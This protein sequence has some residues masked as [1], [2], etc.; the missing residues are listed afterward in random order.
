[1]DFQVTP[2]AESKAL[3]SFTGPG[4]LGIWWG[5]E[6]IEIGLLVSNTVILLVKLRSVRR[7]QKYRVLKGVE[8]T[9][10]RP[11]T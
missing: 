2:L 4:V 9:P 1:M 7:K 10:K 11:N 8:I 3:I 6:N 5:S